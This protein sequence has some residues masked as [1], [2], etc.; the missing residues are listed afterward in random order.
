MKK[1]IKVNC[2]DMDIDYFVSL[3]MEDNCTVIKG[4]KEDGTQVEYKFYG[5]KHPRLKINGFKI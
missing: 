1:F 3:H 4:I 2:K 5:A